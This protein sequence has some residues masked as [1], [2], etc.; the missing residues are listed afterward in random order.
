MSEEKE[1]TNNHQNLFL[2]KD[3]KPIPFF[4]EAPANK[5][6]K[7]KQGYKFGIFSFLTIIAAFILL[8]S[9]TPLYSLVIYYIPTSIQEKMLWP[10][11]RNIT[12]YENPHSFAEPK[13]ISLPKQKL[14]PVLDFDTGICFSFLSTLTNPNPEY[15]N[16]ELLNRAAN[17]KTIA[18]IIAIGTNDKYEYH[19]K[20]VIFKETT[21]N[22]GKTISVICQ[23]FGRAYS[24]TPK[25]ISALYIRPLKPFKAQKT[26]WN[27]IKHLYDDY[28]SPLEPGETNA[29]FKIIP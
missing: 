2:N 16:E 28:T 29:R 7:Q 27:S 4:D 24:S 10:L 21:D 1:E 18:E 5:Q 12:I 9:I 23:K 20:S 17:G 15:I 6:N 25:K 14:L 8:A 11:F 26:V 19:L 13:K 3:G 22:A